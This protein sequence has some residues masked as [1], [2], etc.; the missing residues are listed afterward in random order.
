AAL[1]S[2]PTRRSSA[3]SNRYAALGYRGSGVDAAA[4]SL[5][6]GV[7][8]VAVRELTIASIDTTAL[9][10][11]PSDLSLQP[12]DLFNY[13]TLLDDV[14]RL[15]RGRS[16]DIQLDAGVTPSGGVRVTFRLG[17]P[18]TAGPVERIVFEGNTVLTDEQLREAMRTEVGDNFA[19]A[20][21]NEDFNR[22]IRAYQ[23]AGY[24]VLTTP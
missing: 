18:G 16:S 12:G 20:V 22:I 4:T 14:R 11:D 3:L 6:G 23:E 1:P 15:A 17:A 7:L 24:R 8:D 5:S 9:G 19:S 13:D 2:V 10:V 21:A